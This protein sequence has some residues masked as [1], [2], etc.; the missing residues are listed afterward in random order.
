MKLKQIEDIATKQV[1]IWQPALLVVLLLLGNVIVPNIL[2]QKE[3][4]SSKKKSVGMTLGENTIKKRIEDGVQKVILP[5][6]EELQ[7]EAGKVL[8]IAQ[9]SVQQ[10]VQNFAS[11]SAEQAK[12]FVFD[13]TLGKVLQNINT[14]PTDQ[15][16]LI[17]KA[18][19]K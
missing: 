10:T 3:I 7:K 4:Q 16:E 17:K 2:K 8:G 19:C 11:N 12:E 1:P 18:I 15:Q 13:N 14:L 5:Y 9:V 6:S